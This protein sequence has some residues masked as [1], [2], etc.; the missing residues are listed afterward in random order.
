MIPAKKI[1]PGCRAIAMS[2]QHPWV[3]VDVVRYVGTIPQSSTQ[4][5]WELKQLMPWQNRLMHT[6]E[7]YWPEKSLIRIDDPD[8]A[9]EITMEKVCTI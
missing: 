3:E 5:L 9:L 7:K 4:G 1:V 2:S 8:L 6:K